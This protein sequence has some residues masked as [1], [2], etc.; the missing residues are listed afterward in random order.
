MAIVTPTYRP[1]LDS[2]RRLHESVLRHTDDSVVHH[3][4]VP[5]TDVDAFRSIDSPRLRVWSYRDVAPPGIV[6]TDRLGAITRRLPVISSRVNCA[7]VSRR[8]PWQPI[9]GWVMQQLV[10]L[11]MAAH[12]RADAL[13]FV[14]SDVV[15]VR[16]TDV[17]DYLKDGAVRFFSR[18]DGITRSMT[19]HHRWCQAA[20]RLLG[21]P[22]KDHDTYPDHVAGIVSYDP[23]LVR[24]GLERVEEVTGTPWAQAAARY[25]HFS[26]DTLVGTYLRNFATEEELGYSSEEPRCHSHWSPEPMDEDEA[27]DFVATF[28]PE[29]RAVHIQSTSDT[30]DR[31]I[32]SIVARVEQEVRP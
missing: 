27:E 18:T 16:R 17:D 2:F 24:A 8:R 10:K 23:E 21:L 15:L 14:D 30:D 19:R 6:P 26:E 12:V 31:L 20:H 13:V 22:W 29:H 4:A 3:A 25:L 7:G 9:R 5:G 11:N 32:D 28:G 1:D